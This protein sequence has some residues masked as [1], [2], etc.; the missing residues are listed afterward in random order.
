MGRAMLFSI[1]V[2]GLATAIA[3]AASAPPSSPPPLMGK[4]DQADRVLIEKAAR[5]MTLYR[6]GEALKG[7]EIALGFAPKGDKAREGDGR[8][9]EGVYHIDRRNG[10]SAYHLSLGISYPTPAQRAQARTEGRDPGGDI[11]IHGQPNALPESLTV[12][13]DWTAGCI[14]VSNQEIAEIWA[15]VPIGAKVEIKP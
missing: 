14:A 3:V 8:T 5:R 4:A 9:P 11:F 6:R 1:A 13:G 7:Y 12:P 2:I 10:A 15:M